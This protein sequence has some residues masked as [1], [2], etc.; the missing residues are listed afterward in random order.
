MF[1]AY[2]LAF[3]SKYLE[4]NKIYFKVIDARFMASSVNGSRETCIDY[5]ATISNGLVKSAMHL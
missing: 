5:N 2:A 3:L 4:F 1:R